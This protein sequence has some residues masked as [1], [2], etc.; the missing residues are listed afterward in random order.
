MASLQWQVYT[1]WPE[2]GPH[3]FLHGTGTPSHEGGLLPPGETE[4]PTVS[5]PS[6]LVRH[7]SMPTCNRC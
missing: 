6:E 2:L 1:R 4:P 5:F 7:L 3:L